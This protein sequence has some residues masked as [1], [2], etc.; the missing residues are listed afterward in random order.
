MSY[1]ECIKVCDHIY[2][3][4]KC[5]D[6]SYIECIKVCDHIYTKVNVVT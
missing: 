5:S 4:G 6:M 3:N 1:I 2:T